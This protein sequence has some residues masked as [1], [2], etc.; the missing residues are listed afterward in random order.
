MSGNHIF[1]LE[2]SDFPPWFPVRIS[3]NIQW[4]S[5]YRAIS[6]ISWLSMKSIFAV[7]TR[8]FT[9]PRN[10]RQELNL[11]R[12]FS[13]FSRSIFVQFFYCTKCYFK[14]GVS[15]DPTHVKCIRLG[16]VR[17]SHLPFEMHQVS[18]R[19]VSLYQLHVGTITPL[20]RKFTCSCMLLFW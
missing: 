19:Q 6:A 10:E 20:L 13:D 2:I 9:T 1:L 4:H 12:S 14:L 15:I 8:P 18:V 3:L 11:G 17:S 16:S 5:G 7:E